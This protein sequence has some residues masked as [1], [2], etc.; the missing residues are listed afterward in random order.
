MRTAA[1]NGY[2]KARGLIAVVAFEDLPLT[3]LQLAIIFQ[4]GAYDDAALVVPAAYGLVM[5]G[6]KVMRSSPHR[7]RS[8]THFVPA[9]DVGDPVPRQAC[10]D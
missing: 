9:G 8:S 5:L 3:A 10:R 2:W 4:E 6:H 1:K 7:V